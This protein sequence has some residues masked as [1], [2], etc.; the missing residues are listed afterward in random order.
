MLEARQDDDDD[1]DMYKPDLELNNLYEFV[2][3]TNIDL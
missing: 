2:C 1:D 3:L